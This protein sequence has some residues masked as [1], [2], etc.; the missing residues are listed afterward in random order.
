MDREEHLTFSIIGPG[1]LGSSL[2]DGL[3]RAGYRPLSVFVRSSPENQPFPAAD[4]TLCIN[5][6]P[7]SEEELGRWVFI[8]TQDDQIAPVADALSG[9]DMD[10]RDR[11]LIHCS[12]NLHSGVL[13]AVAEKGAKTAS[14]HPLQTFIRGSDGSAFEG[15]T[16][17]LE[18]DPQ[19]TEELS[20]AVVAMG[21]KPLPLDRD[22][23][24]V[25][26]T[27]AV[28]ISNYT[29]SLARI[30]D[31]LIREALPEGDYRILL[32]L[33]KKTVQNLEE[34]GFGN[35][36]TG[37]VARGDAETIEKHLSVLQNDRELL[38]LYK[39]LGNVALEIS[40]ENE[41]I[42]SQQIETLRALFRN[43]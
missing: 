37:P 40:K 23:K 6:L 24:R 10:W 33:L 19:L 35:A 14:M 8:T 41:T 17:S 7:R 20:A 15:I 25:L 34:S 36:L 27:A 31:R 5:G 30:S 1:R 18:G 29:V 2:L 42:N 11:N 38:S 22:Q 28:F 21:A 9:S 13:E 39:Q 3:K 26:H 16:V 12:G 32:P 4:G 43:K